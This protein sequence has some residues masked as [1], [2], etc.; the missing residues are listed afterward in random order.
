VWAA[1]GAPDA[2]F[3]IAPGELARLAEA[4]VVDVATGAVSG[5]AAS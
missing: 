2:C 1:A 3:P 4:S 5:P